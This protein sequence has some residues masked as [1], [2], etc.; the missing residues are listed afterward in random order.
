M[1]ES[2]EQLV[3]EREL[4]FPRIL[5]ARYSDV[6]REQSFRLESWISVGHFDEPCHEKA[7]TAEQHQTERNL[8]DNEHA[9]E[10]P[11]TRHVPIRAFLEGIV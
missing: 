6:K 5:R 4:P 2:S 11:K 10:A 7:R 9:S 8:N 1:G 3:V